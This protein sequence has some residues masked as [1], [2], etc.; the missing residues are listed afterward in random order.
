MLTGAQIKIN[1]LNQCLY[2]LLKCS[3]KEVYL[4]CVSADLWKEN[5]VA[6]A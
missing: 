3:L 1:L 4:Q 6:Y 2:V 5:L